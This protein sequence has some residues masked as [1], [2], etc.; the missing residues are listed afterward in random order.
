MVTAAETSVTFDRC[1]FDRCPLVVTG[2]AEATTARCTHEAAG[3]GL[4]AAGAGTKVVSRGAAMRRCEQCACAAAG[5]MLE[6]HDAACSGPCIT[7]FEARGPDTYLVMHSCT[8]KS[9]RHVPRCMHQAAATAAHACADPVSPTSDGTPTRD[10]EEGGGV[11]GG[12]DGGHRADGKQWAVCGIWGHSG[13]RLELAHCTVRKMAWGLWLDGPTTRAD[14][15]A[16]RAS[17]MRRG[18]MLAHNGATLVQAPPRC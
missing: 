6:L 16:Y 12:A 7:A 5:A 8:I 18:S 13:A 15:E 11:A 1:H 10:A 9:A 17:G 3:V 2:G 14:V 4:F